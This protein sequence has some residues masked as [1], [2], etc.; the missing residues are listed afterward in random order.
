M[1]PNE[2]N[3]EGV[4]QPQ[5]ETVLDQSQTVTDPVTSEEIVD[6]PSV[7][8]NVVIVA[9]LAVIVLV[10]AFMYIWGSTTSEPNPIVEPEIPV[11]P[12]PEPEVVVPN[13]STSDEVGA[14]EADL[15]AS[16]LETLDSELE[17]METELDAALEEI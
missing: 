6:D 7:S 3:K 12:T 11:V 10:L 9:V 13:V 1:D 15:D 5:E 8:K 16:E 14:L 2:Q 17:Q 4:E